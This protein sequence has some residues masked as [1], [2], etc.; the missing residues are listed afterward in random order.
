MNATIGFF[1]SPSF[2]LHAL[3]FSSSLFFV[4]VILELILPFDAFSRNWLQIS[5]G[6]F[7]K[8]GYMHKHKQILLVFSTTQAE[9]SRGVTS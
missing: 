2:Y 1:S 5:L 9:I 6:W 8:I 4:S 3:S 7:Q